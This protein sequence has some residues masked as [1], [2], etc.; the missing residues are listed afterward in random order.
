MPRS[1]LEEEKFKIL[2]KKY[3]RPENCP[4]LSAPKINSKIWNENL[5]TANR[6]TNISLGK[7]QSLNVS[8][9]YAITETCEKV[10]GWLSK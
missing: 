1:G 4:H 5:L 2:N 10:I 6:M 9:A 8:A 7:I 3:E